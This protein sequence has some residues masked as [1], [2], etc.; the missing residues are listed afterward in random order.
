M[1]AVLAGAWAAVIVLG[2]TGTTSAGEVAES[3][4]LQ[5]NLD[6]ASARIEGRFE[7]DPARP[8]STSLRRFR[9]DPGIAVERVTLAG[10]PL[11]YE[12]GED[13]WLELA[14]S[15]AGERGPLVIAYGARLAAPDTVQSGSGYLGPAGG[16]LPA[17][18]DWYPRRPDAEPHPL[19][20]TLTVSGGHRGVASGSLVAEETEGDQ[21]RATFEHPAARALAAVTGPWQAGDRKVG[22]VTLRTLFPEALEARFGAT[23]RDQAAQYVQRFSDAIGPYPFETFTIAATPR[24][25]GWAFSGFT[26]LGERVIPLP[27][28]PRTSLGHEVLHVW[29]GTSVYVDP[30]GANWSEGLTT[31]MADYQFARERGEARDKRG[32]WL[33]DYAALPEDQDRPL[34]TFRGGN[35]GAVRIAGYHRGAMLWLMLEDWIGRD[36]LRAGARRLFEQWRFREA[37]WEAVTGAFDAITEQDLA[38]FFEQWVR[39]T[40]APE[41]QLTDL[42]LEQRGT[43]WLVSGRLRQ[44]DTTAP[45]SLRIPL[46]VDTEDGRKTRWVEL[47]NAEKAV[48][49]STR[50]RPLAVA[51][52]PDWRVFRHLDSGESPPILRQ[53]V[54]DPDARVIALRGADAEEL[55]VWLGRVPDPADDLGGRRILLGD[56]EA[57]AQWLRAR[58]LPAHPTDVHPDLE[59]HSGSRAWTVPEARLVVIS[60]SDR[61]VRREMAAALRHRA[62]Y[63]YV[64]HGEGN[65]RLAGLWP[66]AGVWQE[67]PEAE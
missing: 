8:G 9:L 54:L 35:A 2:C 49:I 48:S 30:A 10:E 45:W 39:R 6:P 17:G 64:L 31:F 13:G 34:A 40:G 25:V 29:W 46:V 60:G 36:A 26:L 28:I 5:M 67:I 51:V 42:N 19:R 4:R 43:G 23:Y 55:A 38:P 61:S 65:E 56:H 50:S 1:N 12:H 53:A 27:F 22:Q 33:R 7:A 66:Q 3:V 59:A 11:A 62:Q 20:L 37:D 44:A 41:L 32:Q 16:Y 14:R 18:A 24:P 21:Y 57:V 47:Q 63:S 52:D 15:P 58:D